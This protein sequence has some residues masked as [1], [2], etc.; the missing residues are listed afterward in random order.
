MKNILIASLF[1]LVACNNVQEV[2]TS[3]SSVP[4]NSKTEKINLEGGL[5]SLTVSLPLR[6]DTTFTWIHYSD[7]GKPCEKRKYRFQ[8]KT[9]PVYPETGFRYKRLGDSIDQFTII[10]NP[11]LMAGDSDKPDNKKFYYVLSRP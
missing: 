11:Y 8:P 7:C 3:F 5:G 2:K 10:H 9:L 4:E 1:L 6:Y